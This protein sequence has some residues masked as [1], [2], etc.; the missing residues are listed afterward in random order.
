MEPRVFPIKVLKLEIIIPLE[1]KELAVI[2]SF[3]KGIKEWK[4]KNFLSRLSK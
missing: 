1:F 4:P 2:D 3:K